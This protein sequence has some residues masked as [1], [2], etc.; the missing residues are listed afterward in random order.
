MQRL[1]N[2]YPLFLD[3]RGALLD[4]GYVYIGTANEDP[5]ASPLTVYLDSALTIPIAQPLRTRGGLIVNGADPVFIWVDADDYSLRTR[6]AD[7]NEITFTPSV[8]VAAA[9][10]VD[11][12]PLDADLTAI[13]A[14]TTTAFGRSFLTQADAAAVKTLLGIVAGIPT[15]GGTVTGNLTRSGAGVHLYHVDPA[16]V[17]GRVFRTD[18]AASDPTTLVGDIWIKTAS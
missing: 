11:Y 1:V 4:A 5:E 14:L 8:A 13:A 12:Q 9:A 3:L 7:G 6:D 16:Y 18:A 2:P 10:E 17:S 15:T